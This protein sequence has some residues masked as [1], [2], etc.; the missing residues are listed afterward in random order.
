MGGGKNPGFVPG[1]PMSSPTVFSS[2]FDTFRKRDL[3]G[4]ADNLAT[5]K[6]MSHRVGTAVVARAESGLLSVA[7]SYRRLTGGECQ[8]R[9]KNCQQGMS[10][11]HPRIET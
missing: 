4:L 11:R 1:S 8:K 6:A 5:D 3:V 10:R 9:D 7:R 2:R